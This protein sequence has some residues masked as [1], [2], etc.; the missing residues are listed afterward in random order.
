MFGGSSGERLVSVAS[1]QNLAKN[2]SFSELWFFSE[3]GE[4]HKV[5]LA[6][7]LEH[8]DPFKK[9]FR[10]QKNAFASGFGGSLEF[11]NKRKVF[12]GFHG[13]EGED[14]SFQELLEKKQILFTGSGSA[15]S[16]LCFNKKLAKEVASKSGIH[17]VSDFSFSTREIS[18]AYGPLEEYLREWGEIV[19]KPVANGSS[20]G[21]F[22]ISEDEGLERA[23]AAMGDG[24]ELDY[25][26]EPF[27]KGRELTVGVL[28]REKVTEALPPSE[29]LLS[30]GASFDYDGKYLGR[31]TKEVT[32]AALAKAEWAEAQRVALL[33]HK[34]L[35]CYGYSRTDLILKDDGVV[36]FLE[37]NT[38][39]G[40]TAASF[41]PQ[42]LAVAGIKMEDFV[43][44]QL[45]LAEF[46]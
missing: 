24:A 40:V 18:R 12:L 8:Q 4:A 21:L 26:A 14:G 44:G 16:K 33:A 2:Y 17:T 35:G 20:I 45:E 3:K 27:V 34:C 41:L 39:P 19:L 23:L 30:Q 6:E 36:V 25:L 38:L 37:T 15:S 5:S 7:L 1:A 32:P 13:T 31:G 28:Q 10:P 9:Q 42:Q 11:V 46:R 29:V 22:V 43:K